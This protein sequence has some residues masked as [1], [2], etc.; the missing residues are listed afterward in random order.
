M[1]ENKTMLKYLPVEGEI[2]EGVRVRNIEGKIF[3]M[4]SSCNH[5]TETEL[6]FYKIVERYAVSADHKIKEGDQMATHE[7]LEIAEYDG[8][9]FDKDGEFCYKALAP[10]SPQV[11]WEILDGAVIEGQYG[12][13]LI[14]HNWLYNNEFDSKIKP[15]IFYVKGP[16][17]H[18]H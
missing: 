8:F 4:S 9:S 12:K 6:S 14:L 7:G 13:W 1:S 2:K 3:T 17:G 15:D 11:T 18:Y 10:I 16:C 5:M